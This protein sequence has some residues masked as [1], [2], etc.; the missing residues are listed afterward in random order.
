MLCASRT[1]TYPAEVGGGDAGKVEPAGG[2]GGAGE[3]DGD[4]EEEG[5]RVCRHGG[6]A[7]ELG[8]CDRGEGRKKEGGV[9]ERSRLAGSG[10]G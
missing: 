6:F 5:C 1:E 3:E 4:E 2:R 8:L 10:R 9:S 7:S